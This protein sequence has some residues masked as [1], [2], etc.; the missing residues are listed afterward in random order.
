M[1]SSLHPERS[2][3]GGHGRRTRGAVMSTSVLLSVPSLG[4]F[5]LV[6]RFRCL[7]VMT[8]S[9]LP[10]TLGWGRYP[11]WPSLLPAGGGVTRVISLS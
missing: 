10:Y 4:L 1:G 7:S 6:R 11:Q 8:L 3:N 9:F 2:M 5:P